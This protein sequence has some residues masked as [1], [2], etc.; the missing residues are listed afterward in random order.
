FENRKPCRDVMIKYIRRVE[1]LKGILNTKKLEDPV[2][3]AAAVQMLP[4]NIFTPNEF[5]NGPSITTQIHQKATAKYEKEIRQELFETNLANTNDELRQRHINSNNQDED[6]NAV[7]NY[8]HKMQEKIAENMILMTNNMKEHALT[9]STI[10]KK[11]LSILEKSDK[12]A[13]NNTT[14]LK[15]EAFKL[16]EHTKSTWRCWLWVMIAFVL[17]VFFNMILFIK[18]VKKKI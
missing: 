16:G 15:D 5:T 10:I 12:L 7:L 18:I 6:I 17:V 2:E 4:V 8:H 14:K 1:F 11:D 3:R 9:A 13:D